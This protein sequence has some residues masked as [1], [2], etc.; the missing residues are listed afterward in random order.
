MRTTLMTVV[1]LTGILTATP[2]AASTVSTFDVLVASDTLI[3]AGTT[4]ISGNAFS[5]GG[6]TFAVSRGFVGIGTA[7]PLNVIAAR[8]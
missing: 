7:T 2:S 1:F 6:S 8:A 5:V 4:T 3:V